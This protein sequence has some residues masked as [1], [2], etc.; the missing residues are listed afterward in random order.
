MTGSPGT[1]RAAKVSNLLAMTMPRL[2]PHSAP[3]NRALRCH[4]TAMLLSQCVRSAAAIAASH[5]VPKS[6]VEIGEQDGLRAAAG[7]AACRMR[8][9]LERRRPNRLEPAQDCRLIDRLSAHQGGR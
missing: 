6:G 4:K 9:E 2:G 7:G 8:F 5:G 1:C 3:R